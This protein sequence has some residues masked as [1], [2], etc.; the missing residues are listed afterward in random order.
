MARIKVIERDE[1]TGELTVAGMFDPDK[2][3]KWE[4][5]TEWDGNNSADVHVGANR[6]QDLYRTAGGKWVLYGWSNWVNEP[7]SYEFISADKAK[8]WLLI[9]DNDEAVVEFFGE[10]DEEKAP[11]PGRPKVGEPFQF[12]FP[13]DLRAKVAAKATEGE[14]LGATVRRLLEQATA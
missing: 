12:A 2:A 4:G 8:D 5:R 14:S 10:I 7:D 13:E 11:G 6:G 3:H 1:I 9:N